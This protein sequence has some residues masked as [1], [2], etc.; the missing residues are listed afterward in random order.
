[1]CIRDREIGLFRYG[2]I[3]P[4]SRSWVDDPSTRAVGAPAR[5]TGPRGSVRGPGPGFA[6]DPGPVDPGLADRRLRRPGAFGPPRRAPHARVGSGA[7]GGA[8]TGGPRTDRR[9]GRG[10][11][12]RTCRLGTFGAD[13][14]TTLR[15]PGAGHPPQ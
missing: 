3:R 1:M 5:R 4:G 6:G 11:P 15:P 7:G 14:A 8:E 10:D 9:P 13:P 12:G 2:L